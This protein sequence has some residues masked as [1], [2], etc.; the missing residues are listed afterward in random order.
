MGIL[1]DNKYWADVVNRLD[2][3]MPKLGE[4]ITKDSAMQIRAI[5]CEAL[6]KLIQDPDFQKD[7]AHAIELGMKAT[8][9]DDP[10][11]PSF[12]KFLEEFMLHEN[13]ILGDSGVKTTAARDLQNE[14]YRIAMDRDQPKNR[15]DR[16]DAKIAFCAKLACDPTIPEDPKK[17]SLFAVALKA[18]KGVAVIGMDVGTA[19]A[20]AVTLGPA[21]AAATGTVAGISASYGAAMVADA[22]KER[23]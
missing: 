23:F 7:L 12:P 21:G 20:A 15:F 10:T 5:A 9:V 22:V 17:P 8:V 14:I 19:A 2:Q 13:K 6:T 3:L 16:L 1:L 11:V 4:T 18:V